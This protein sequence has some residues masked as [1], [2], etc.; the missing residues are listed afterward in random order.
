M[1]IEAINFQYSEKDIFQTKFHYSFKYPGKKT[2][3]RS[4]LIIGQEI[5]DQPEFGFPF[6][7]L[8]LFKVFFRF[9]LRS[10]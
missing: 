5:T 9:I 4:S 2:P 1:C 3:G 10:G 6:V 8:K 7:Q